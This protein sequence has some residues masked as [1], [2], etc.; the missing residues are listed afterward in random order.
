METGA[1]GRADQ[2][3]LVSTFAFVRRRDGRGGR[4]VVKACAGGG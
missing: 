4:V 3:A 2:G 1:G